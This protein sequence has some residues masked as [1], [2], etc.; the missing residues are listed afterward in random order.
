M[1]TEEFMNGFRALEINAKFQNLSR[2]QKQFESTKEK[3]D[4]QIRQTQ[5]ELIKWM[6]NTCFEDQNFTEVLKGCNT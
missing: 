1:T 4:P 6:R 3:L 5:Q 2:I